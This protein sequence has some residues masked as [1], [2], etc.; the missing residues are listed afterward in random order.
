MGANKILITAPRPKWDFPSQRSQYIGHGINDNPS[1]SWGLSLK[2]FARIFK[3]LSLWVIFLSGS[4]VIVLGIIFANK[5][6]TKCFWETEI[7][8]QAENRAN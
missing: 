7:E 8:K 2:L 3:K 1:L 4:V 5:D 6:P